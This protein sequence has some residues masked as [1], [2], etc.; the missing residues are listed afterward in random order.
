MSVSVNENTAT[1][2]K[3]ISVTG[4]FD[5]SAHQDFIKSYKSD[6]KGSKHYIIDLVN[7]EYMDS[8]AMGMLL[9]LREY[10][11]SHGVELINGNDNIKEVIRI[12]NFDKLFKVA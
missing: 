11:G 5:F 9:Q 2:D 3:T 6:D 7:T 1:G 8:S 12:A 10:S 4:R